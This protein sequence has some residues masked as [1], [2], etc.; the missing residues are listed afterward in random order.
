[1]PQHQE[2]RVLPYTPQQIFDLVVDVKSY[3]EFLP[4]CQNSR[5]YKEQEGNFTADVIIGYKMIRERY[6]STVH[7]SSPDGSTDCDAAEP[8][9]VS[10]EYLNG[11]FKYLQNSWKFVPVPAEDGTCTHCEVHFFINYEFRSRLLQK[12]A[13]AVFYEVVRR[14]IG[15]FESAAEKRYGTKQQGMIAAQKPSEA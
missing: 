12:V 7:Y 1:M 15:A 13:D 3:P 11:P 4:W 5:V 8:G 6:T 10:V 14:M 9:S 2:T